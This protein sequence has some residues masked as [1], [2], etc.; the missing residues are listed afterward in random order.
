VRDAELMLSIGNRFDAASTCPYTSWRDE[1]CL[2]E[3]LRASGFG[4]TNQALALAARGDERGVRWGE[5]SEDME[6]FGADADCDDLYGI[7]V[8]GI[9]ECAARKCSRLR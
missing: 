1:P 3:G 2:S 9:R 6:V 4:A 8:K 7:R 5:S